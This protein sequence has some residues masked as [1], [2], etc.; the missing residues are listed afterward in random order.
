MPI[1]RAG[2]SSHSVIIIGGGL[3][4]LSVLHALASQDPSRRIENIRLLEKEDRPGGTIQTVLEQSCLFEQGP[5]AFLDSRASTLALINELGLAHELLRADPAAADRF[6]AV[7]GQLHS[8]PLSPQ[9]LLC[10]S[11]MTMAGK[12]RIL[13]E[14][15]IARGKNPDETVYEFGRRRLGKAFARL[16]LDPMVSG[17]FAGNA[18]ELILKEAFPKIYK[19]EQEYGSLVR[20]MLALR[21][22]KKSKARAGQP[23]GDLRSL[24]FGMG[25]LT[26]TLAAKY[27]QYIQCGEAVLRVQKTSS[28]YSIE[29]NRGVYQAD[30]VICSAPAY[31]AAEFLEPLD[32]ALAHSLSK[33]HYA[34]LAVTGWSFPKTSFTR[35]PQGF[36]YLIPSSENKQVLGVLLCSNLFPGRATGGNI[37][38]RVM[39]GGARH[40]DILK[41]SDET[42]LSMAYNELNTTYGLNGAPTARFLARWPKAIPQYDQGYIKL[43]QSILDQAARH[44]GLYLAANYIGGVSMNDCTDNARTFADNLTSKDLI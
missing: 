2:R 3:S 30:T 42:L 11:P 4:G 7:S 28:G 21:A 44:Q 29:S 10:F 1:N 27:S 33:V 34:P 13:A 31:T 15:F 36:G 18:S 12:L 39:I 19:I 23:A 5:N 24:R 26:T 20:G 16:F 8:M 25:Q 32:P 14:P 6:I 40:P 35:I 37:M 38:L 41:K 17:I 9:A 43:K 22:Q